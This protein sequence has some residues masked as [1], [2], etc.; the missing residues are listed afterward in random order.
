[1]NK[2]RGLLLPLSAKQQDVVR[3]VRRKENGVPSV[4]IFASAESLFRIDLFIGI[5]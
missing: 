3:V 4:G 2:R 1:M 5:I